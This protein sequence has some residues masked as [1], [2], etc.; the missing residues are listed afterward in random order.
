MTHFRIRPASVAACIALATC[1]L[2]VKAQSSPW[3]VGISQ[4]V[5]HDS[6]L[7]R[8]DDNGV[9][10]AGYSRSDTIATTSLIGGL[11]QQISRQRLYGNATV[12]MNRYRDNSYLNNT[13]YDLLA[14]LDWAT[15]DRLSGTLSAASNRQLNQF[16]RDTG[17]NQSVQTVK[18]VLT[19]NQLN[20]K[21]TF[22]GL[23]R[24][25]LEGNFGR[26]L[27]SYSAPEFFDS[28]YH[29]T[30][31]S[32]GVVYRTG[33]TRFHVSAKLADTEYSADNVVHRSSLNFETYWP[34]S[35][36]SALWAR[37]S[38]TRVRYDVFD[39]RDFS[40]VTGAL[41][42]FWTPSGRT[43]VTTTYVHDIGLDSSFETFGGPIVAGTSDISRTSDVVKIDTRYDL[44]GKV[45]LSA[46]ASMVKRQLRQTL[47]AGGLVANVGDGSDR[48]GSLSLGAQW[49]PRR[50]VQF[51][52]S[53]SRERRSTSGG[54]TLPYTD[55]SANCYGQLTLQ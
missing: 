49:T 16:N 9:L 34:A 45:V 46:G 54:F 40:G 35:G 17:P 47:S 51:G 36:N 23:G 50:S 42:W 53:L 26:R 14:G 4:A 37:L 5:A 6:N 30:S 8:I 55:S 31:G 32:L 25:A 1:S 29:Q 21:F 24:L 15:I 27:V 19:T 38:P 28:N 10:P 48:I 52:C 20:A 11:D 18:N 33:M 43:H 41:A 13:S 39:E 2:S 22:G 12:R 44:S 7:Y 3:Y